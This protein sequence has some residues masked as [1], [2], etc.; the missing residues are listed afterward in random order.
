[1]IFASGATPIARGVRTPRPTIIDAS[2]VPCSD[3]APVVASRR[4]SPMNAMRFPAV[5]IRFVSVGCVASWS[6]TYR[7]EYGSGLTPFAMKYIMPPETSGIPSR[8][9]E[10][11]E[12]SESREAIGFARSS[13]TSRAVKR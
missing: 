13:L 11:V 3:L 6:C 2:R 1:M 4:N 9:G 8:P 10:P 5:G 7:S 12:S